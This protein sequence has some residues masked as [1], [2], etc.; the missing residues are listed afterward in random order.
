VALYKMFRYHI[1]G[2]E[3]GVYTRPDWK[4]RLETR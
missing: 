1:V 2:S 3:K 4:I